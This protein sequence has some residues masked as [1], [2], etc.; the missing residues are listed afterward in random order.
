M[1][2]INWSENTTCTTKKNTNKENKVHQNATS[3][4]GKTM[5]NKIKEQKHDEINEMIKNIDKRCIKVDIEKHY[6]KN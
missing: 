5:I 6:M 3:G 4:L 1:Q 2:K